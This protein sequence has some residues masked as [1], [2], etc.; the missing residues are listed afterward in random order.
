MCPQKAYLSAFRAWI[1]ELETELLTRETHQ[2]V[3]IIEI[4]ISPI[5]R[6]AEHQCHNKMNSPR[7]KFDVQ[8]LAA[9]FDSAT[10]NPSIQL[11]LPF[12]PYPWTI[13]HGSQIDDWDPL[14]AKRSCPKK[15]YG[16]CE[17]A[18]FP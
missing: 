2:S 1:L 3:E 5:M 14:N 12:T 8:I 10:Y 13:F 16:L 9:L 15:W 17:N 11:G 18:W 6:L 4:G 7:Y